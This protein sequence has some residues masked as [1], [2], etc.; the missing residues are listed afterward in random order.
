[1]IHPWFLGFISFQSGFTDFMLQYSIKKQHIVICHSKHRFGMFINER[2]LTCRIFQ[3]S[4]RLLPHTWLKCY[5]QNEK[6]L[7][8]TEI[9]LE[10]KASCIS[11]NLASHL[12]RVN[13]QQLKDN[14][15]ITEIKIIV[16][17]I[18]INEYELNQHM[19]NQQQKNIHDRRPK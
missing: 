9:L 17:I 11:I 6:S 16:N 1:M 14:T 19:I 3:M 8:L 18:I 12:E 2:P 15:K 10:N 7:I 4:K 13:E 5:C